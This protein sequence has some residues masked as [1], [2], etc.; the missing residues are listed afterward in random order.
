MEIRKPSSLVYYDN[1]V[2]EYFGKIV[3]EWFKTNYLQN[4]LFSVSNAQKVTS[5]NARKVVHF[6][7]S[8]NYTSRKANEKIEDM[9]LIV[10]ILKSIIPIVWKDAP[11]N[12]TQK[13]N[14]C[15]INRYLPGQGI[16][17]HIDKTDDFGDTIVCFT[18]GSGREMEF[19]KGNDIF[20]VYTKSLSM[21]VMV[22]DARYDWKHAMR[23][24][25]K[26]DGIPR[27]TVYSIT[28]REVL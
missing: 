26:D 13:L 27:G 23:Q 22:K 7:Y 28:F 3:D 15:I 11:P 12:I 5:E 6:G 10:Q 24:K 2:N 14:Q 19:S 1:A 8:Y 20:K 25:K 9:P 4:R 18:F 17:S 21:Y 16:G